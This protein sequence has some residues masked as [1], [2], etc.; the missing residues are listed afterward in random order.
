MDT[1]P[2][3]TNVFNP[4]DMFAIQINYPNKMPDKFDKWIPKFSGNNVLYTIKENIH[5]N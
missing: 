2:W 4:L 5:M 1:K 3:I